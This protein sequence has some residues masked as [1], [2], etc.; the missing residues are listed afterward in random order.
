MNR[1]IQ[2]EHGASAG[3]SLY[4]TDKSKAVGENRHKKVKEPTVQLAQSSA[5]HYCE[6]QVLLLYWHLASPSLKIRIRHSFQIIIILFFHI[7]L[8]FA[9]V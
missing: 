3:K 6:S 1:T 2:W 4:L 9:L 5:V 8:L 7:D